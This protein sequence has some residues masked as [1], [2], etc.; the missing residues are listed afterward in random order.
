M[1]RLKKKGFFE[2]VTLKLTFKREER[3]FAS[4]TKGREGI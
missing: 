1:L 2:K 3:E 4:Q